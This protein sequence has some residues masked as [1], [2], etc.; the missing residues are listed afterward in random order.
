MSSSLTLSIT[1]KERAAAERN[2]N[3]SFILPLAELANEHFFVK[4]IGKG[5]TLS[6]CPFK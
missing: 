4:I 1:F 2:I 3:S 5:C 6:F